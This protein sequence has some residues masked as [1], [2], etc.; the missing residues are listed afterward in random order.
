MLN[1]VE[2]NSTAIYIEALETKNDV[3]IRFLDPNFVKVLC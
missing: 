3:T 2:R 1:G